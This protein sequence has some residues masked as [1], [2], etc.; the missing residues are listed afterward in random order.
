MIRLKIHYLLIVFL[1][2]NFVYGCAKVRKSAGAV[3]KTPDEYQAIENPPLVI[4]PDYNLIPPNQLQGKNIENIEKE[5]AKE[6]LFGLESENTNEENQLST[7][8][9]IVS[10][11]NTENVSNSIRD[12][13]DEDFAKELNTSDKFQLKWKDEK[14]ILDAVKESERI[15]K[16][17]FNNES[18]TEVNIPIKKQ[19]V[20]K[21]K[22][23]FF[24]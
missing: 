19:K 4:P 18:I 9:K 3:R 24:F 13:I 17:N 2:L 20:K 14:E 10:K 22:R 12:E 8:N 5:L 11:A 7:M 1:T 15:R 16:N 23:F 21:K 6:I